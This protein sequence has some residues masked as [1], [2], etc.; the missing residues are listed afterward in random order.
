MTS[1]RKSNSFIP[2]ELR[3]LSRVELQRGR[4]DYAQRRSVA[5]GGFAAWRSRKSSVPTPHA[6]RRPS[7]PRRRALRRVHDVVGAYHD[8]SNA[9]M[10]DVQGTLR[11]VAQQ[12]QQVLAAAACP[13]QP[14]HDGE[15]SGSGSGSTQREATVNAPT[16]CAHRQ[17][18]RSMPQPAAAAA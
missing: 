1:D 7:R 4:V 13:Q 8:A 11:L 9:L 17:R 10:R 2:S 3:S 16:V 6:R 12:Q 5:A 18:A 14:G 15:L